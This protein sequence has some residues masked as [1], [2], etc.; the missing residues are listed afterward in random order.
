MA[1]PGGAAT[2]TGPE[3]ISMLPRKG[4]MPV[5]SKRPA[6]RRQV[7]RSESKTHDLATAVSKEV[8]ALGAAGLKTKPPV[9]GGKHL[10]AINLTTGSP[11]LG[12]PTLKPNPKLPNPPSNGPQGRRLKA[13]LTEIYRDGLPSEQV[14]PNYTV[15]LK[16]EAFF[17]KKE[18]SGCPVRKT[19]YR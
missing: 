12:T 3:R 15:A 11:D 10:G 18:W 14:A 5:Q 6:V 8:H 1:R 13:V 17:K 4:T 19:I 16:I 2:L 7:H 9:L